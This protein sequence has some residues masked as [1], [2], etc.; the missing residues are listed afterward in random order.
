MDRS[1]PGLPPFLT[2]NREGLNSGFMIPQYTAASIVS[3]NKVLCHPGAADSI[4]T[5]ANQEDI[6]SMGS[7]SAKKLLKILENTEQ[8]VGIE[9]MTALQALDLSLKGTDLKSSPQLESIR[10][11]CRREIPLVTRDIYLKPLI[12]RAVSLVREGLE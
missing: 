3:E 2:A 10:R 7:I 8:V 9:L 6:N 5:S 11:H 1:P 12:D 4:P